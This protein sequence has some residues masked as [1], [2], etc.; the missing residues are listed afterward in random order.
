MVRQT[1]NSMAWKHLGD[2]IWEFSQEQGGDTACRK[3]WENSALEASV[4][5]LDDLEDFMEAKPT[6]ETTQ[7]L[8]EKFKKALQ[9][10]LRPAAET[11]E[12]LRPTLHYLMLSFGAQ[13]HLLRHSDE[14]EA[15]LARM[16]ESLKNPDTDP[17]FSLIDAGKDIQ[18]GLA[19]NRNRFCQAQLQILHEITKTSNTES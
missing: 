5:L 7:T 6:P 2:L 4:D 10:P 15:I 16:V 11:L 3:I 13:L 17:V 12:E 19:E 18:L 8:G 14:G 1:A 9:T